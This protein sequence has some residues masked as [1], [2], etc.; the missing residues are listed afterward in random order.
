[1][2]KRLTTEEE[3]KAEKWVQIH[4]PGWLVPMMGF[5]LQDPSMFPKSMFFK[6]VIE[7]FTMSQWW[8]LV[9]KRSTKK[10]RLI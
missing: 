3:D 1:M 2:R 4:H 10:S 7:K 8:H 9:E 5:K 6:G